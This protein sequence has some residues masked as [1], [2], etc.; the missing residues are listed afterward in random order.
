MNH[1]SACGSA[2][3]FPVPLAKRN[4][5]IEAA[6]PTT[7]VFTLDFIWCKVSKIASPAVIDPPGE[8]NID[9]KCPHDSLSLDIKAQR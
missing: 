2:I 1:T 9:V 4:A 3:L 7:M 8:E 6:I 5:A